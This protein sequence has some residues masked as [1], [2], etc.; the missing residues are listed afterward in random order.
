MNENYITHIL[1]EREPMNSKTD[2]ARLNA[3]TDT[4]IEQAVA[5]DPDSFIPD[6]SW[7]DKAQ[8]VMP[9]TKETITLRLDPEVIAWFRLSGKGYQTRINAVL[10]AFVKAQEQQHFTR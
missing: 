3:M 8:V 6:A 10:Q 5:D 4:D 1:P 9:K 2:W 7:W